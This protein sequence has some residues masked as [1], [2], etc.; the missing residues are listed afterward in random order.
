M[1]I[2]ITD[3]PV[4]LFLRW[5]DEAREAEPNDPDAA[6]LATATPDAAPSARMVLVRQVDADG[7]AFY[8]NLESQKGHELTANARAALCYHWKSLRRQVRIE[9]SVNAVEDETADAY[10]ASRSRP[11]QI[12]AWASKQSEPL[13]SRFELERRVAVQAAKFG[14]GAVPRPPFWSGF[15]LAPLRIEFWR[16]GAF[17][18]HD[19][20][21]YERESVTDS[22][23]QTVRL[24]P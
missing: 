16:N 3:D 11:S 22:V 20:V 17:R 23:W 13:T 18:L 2:P 5:L 7:F 15:R 4:S 12:G 8:T 14:V 6:C 9:G 24:F 10:F 21:V 19:R 1:S